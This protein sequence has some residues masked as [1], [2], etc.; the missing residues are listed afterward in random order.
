MPQTVE[1]V[2]AGMCFAV[3]TACCAG[4]WRTM[5]GSQLRL[6]S[7]CACYGVGSLANSFLPARAGDAVR[8]GLFSRVSPGGMLAVAG[9]VAAVGI[10]RWLALLPLGVA[11]IVDSS[12]PPLAIALCGRGPAPRSGVAPRSARFGARPRAPRPTSFRTAGD[13]LR[14]GRLGAR[15]TRRTG[16]GRNGVPR[17]R[18]A[19]A[20]RIDRGTRAACR[21]DGGGN[22]SRCD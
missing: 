11:G 5:L 19:D 13:L 15:H 7:A 8:I 22:R 14:P 16:R 1:L 21:R 18:N 4:S 9:A 10:A 3:A 20:H 2:A 17:P 12:L 6:G